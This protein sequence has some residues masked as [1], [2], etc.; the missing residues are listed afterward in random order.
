MGEGDSYAVGVN[1]SAQVVGSSNIGQTGSDDWPLQHAFLW[2]GGTMVDLGVLSGDNA[3]H[4]NAI[5]R[6]GEIVGRS[7]VN[8]DQ[9][10]H[11]VIWRNGVIID[12]NRLLARKIPATVVLSNAPSIADS[13]RFEV[14]GVDSATGKRVSYLVTPTYSTS[15]RLTSSPNP[16]VLGQP[17]IFS[18]NVVTTDNHGTPTGWVIFKDA[19][20]TLT[21]VKLNASGYA[22]YGTSTLGLGTHDITATYSR[23]DVYGAS[24]SAT[25][26][27]RVISNS[28]PLSRT[29]AR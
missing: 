12:L 4:A 9:S 2:Q 11:A 14:D 23:Q 6:W 20:T 13:G 28:I 1:D 25:V 27:Q 3:S 21:T 15:V 8:F 26:S 19:T 7:G 5:N 10:Y 22:L 24:N 18:A 17:V 16:S 29:N